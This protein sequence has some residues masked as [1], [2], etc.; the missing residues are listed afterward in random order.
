MIAVMALTRRSFFALF[1]ALFHPVPRLNLHG[2]KLADQNLK[3][4]FSIYEATLGEKDP[5]SGRGLFNPSANV[6]KQYDSAM[7]TLARLRSE[8][9]DRA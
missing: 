8:D 7:I 5:Y 2:L 1:A 9:A 4:T 6:A 3:G